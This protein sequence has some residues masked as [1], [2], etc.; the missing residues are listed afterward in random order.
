VALFELH[1]DL[2]VESVRAAGGE[3]RWV[4]SGNL[5]LVALAEPAPSGATLRVEIGFGGRLLVRDDQRLVLADP[6]LWHPRAGDLERAAY[7]VTLTWPAAL[8]LVA[9]G[10]RTDGGIRADG[11]KWERRVVQAPS[12]GFGFEVGRY[13]SERFRVGEIDVVLA[14]DPDGRRLDKRA[15]KQI[16]D[17]VRSALEY[18]TETFGPP[19]IDEL[20]VAT[21]P[22]FFSQS[23]P[24]FVTLSSVMMNDFGGYAALFGIEDRRSVVAHEIAHQWWGHRVGWRSYRDQW[25]SE[26]LAQYSAMAWARARLPADERPRVGPTYGWRSVL[27]G[28]TKDGRTI[29]SLGPIVLGSRLASSKAATAYLP[30]VYKKGAIVLDMLANTVGPE[31]FLRFLRSLVESAGGTAI[32]TAELL[33]AIERWHGSSLSVLTDRFVYGTG[34]PEFLYDYR[35]AAEGGKWV[36]EG[37]ARQ[38]ATHRTLFA[39]ESDDRG[40]LRVAQR[41]AARTDSGSDAIVAPFQVGIWVPGA[42]DEKERRRVE[43]GGDPEANQTIKGR[44]VL[45][46]ETTPFR[47]EIDQQPVRLWLDLRD[48]AFATFYDAGRWPKR[49]AYQRARELERRRELSEAEGALREAL[50]APYADESVE[51][52]DTR[53]RYQTRRFDARIRLLLVE[54][55]LD[56]GDLSAAEAELG[57]FDRELDRSTRHAFRSWHAL[58]EGRIA[59][60]RARPE[61]AYRKLRK[62]RFDSAEAN[63]YLALAAKATSRDDEFRKAIEAARRRGAEVGAAGLP[64]AK[65]IR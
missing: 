50:A 43:R 6:V 26:G 1:P 19:G 16:R 38:I 39:L 65:T 64:A 35:L 40:E 53:R 30:I 20:V 46:G 57:A 59:L 63:L 7:D 58:V 18:F 2:K 49:A 23:L 33:A 15:K 5:L 42:A 48:E 62:V 44:M 31:S 12:L 21:T 14:F 13:R 61:E 22:R 32:S 54:L 3:L 8:E 24:G 11:R 52:T 29:E 17:S 27:G 36:V 28:T 47:I 55:A 10:R 9:G 4:R 56:R 51:M 60:A 41:G 34:V 25:I 37:S 45:D